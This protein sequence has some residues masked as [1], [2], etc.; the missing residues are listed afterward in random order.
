MNQFIKLVSDEELIPGLATASEQ[1]A[2]IAFMASSEASHLT[3][4]VVETGRRGPRISKVLG[5]VP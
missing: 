5:F 3:G 2:V 4:E 1:A